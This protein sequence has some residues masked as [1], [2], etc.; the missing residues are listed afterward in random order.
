MAETN[1]ITQIVCCVCKESKFL[2][3]FPKS[4]DGK[5][6]RNTTCKAC[7]SSYLKAYKIANQEKLQEYARQRY[8]EKKTEYSELRKKNYQENKERYKKNAKKWAQENP[9][10]RRVIAKR[11]EQENP[12]KRH[13]VQR[14][15]RL[16]NPGMYAAHFKARQQRKRQAMPAWADVES[17]K[18][19]YRQS[20]WVTKI[21][22]IK[23][24]VD[25]YYPLQSDIVCGLHVGANLR[26]IPA[27]VN[28]R[29]HN[30]FPDQ[31]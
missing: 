7:R 1:T 9:D 2:D 26:I 5:Y 19:L 20:A 10:K 22:G 30:H 16:S 28:L 12:E 23:H 4:K 6:G 31:E 25:H 24:H 8:V 11:W 13:E 18:A 29:K 27:K 21:T 17:I 14:N 15:N 3:L